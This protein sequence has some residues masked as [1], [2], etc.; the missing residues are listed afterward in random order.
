[1]RKTL[2]IFLPLVGLAIFVW[3]VRGAGIGRIW[4]AFQGVDPL[5]LLIFPVFTVVIVWLRGLRWWLLLKGAGVDYSL[6]RSSVVWAIGFFAAAVTPGK[7]GDA[8]RAFYV[9]RETGRGVGSA[10]LTVFVDRL[11]DLVTILVF[12]VVTV[13][14]FSY[15]YTDLPSIWVIVAA[16]LVL[17]ALL[18]LGLHRGLVRRFLGPLFRALTPAK[19]RAQLSAEVDGFYDALGLYAGRPGTTVAAAVLTL[20]YWLWIVLMAYA[21]T[22][23]LGIDVSL[24]YVALM[25]PVMTLMEIIPISVSGIG[26]REA[27]V[28]FFFSAVGIGNAQAVAFSIMYLI[29]GTYLTALVGFG[30]WLANPAKFGR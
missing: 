13:L 18:Y 7:V 8:V 14:V 2:S 22:W 21:V 17:L 11:M 19:Y 27:A 1:M 3:I 30:A 29:V 5:R 26:T 28:V 6:R 15:V 25:L 16:S 20:V 12:G 9:S 10:F 23:V 24:R 4:Q